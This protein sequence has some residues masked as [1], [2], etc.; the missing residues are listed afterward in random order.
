[1]T[2]FYKT[3]KSPVGELKLIASDKGLAAVLWENDDPYRVPMDSME[4]DKNH[5]I[6][7]DAER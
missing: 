5:P 6:L 4:E 1:M 2:Y 7:R 3:I